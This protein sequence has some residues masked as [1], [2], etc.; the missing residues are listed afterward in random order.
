MNI[1]GIETSCDETAAA[2][3]YG[4]EEKTSGAPSIK[5]LS[6]IIYSQINIHREWGG[7]VPEIAAREHALK[8][9]PVIN[10]ALKKAK[11]LPKKIDAI[12]VTTGPGLITSLS[13]GVETAKT[14][15]YAWN[16]SI[17]PVNHI[18]AHIYANFLNTSNKTNYPAL[19]L[20]VSG[21]HTMLI[22]MKKLGDM[23]IIGNTRDDAAGEAFDKGA[24]MMG[25]KYPGGPEISAYA[26]KLKSVKKIQLPR[27]MINSNDFN[28][29]FSGLKTSLRYC[30]QKDSCWKKNIPEYCHEY[31]QAIIDVLIHKTIKAAQKFNIK[32]VMLAGGVIANT[33][34][35]HQFK[36]QIKQKL[37]N[38]KYKIPDT[39]YTTDNAAMI[40]SVGYF[41]A[42]NKHF[43][44]WQD[45]KTVN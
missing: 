22:L 40:G 25:L 8:I 5:V 42:K 35:K 17:T 43:I 32:T 34:L 11:I 37:P 4:K 38:I 36:K 13:V 19:A 30:L 24:K 2:I 3:V 18:E 9:I 20:T 28:F 16:I 26:K 7:V 31:Q 1:L 14:L 12:A 27:P 10:N 39:E 21:G 45:L 6:N 23:K 33:E 41:K 29:S 15:S 44:S